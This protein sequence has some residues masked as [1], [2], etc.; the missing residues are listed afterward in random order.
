MHKF[1]PTQ[2]NEE[3]KHQSGQRRKKKVQYEDEA[4]QSI[5]ERGSI[6]QMPAY[7]TGECSA[8]AKCLAR[9][10]KSQQSWS[11]FLQGRGHVVF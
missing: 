4:K 6:N 7:I 5:D 3:R 9:S 2:G 10:P 1:K 11:Q 8:H